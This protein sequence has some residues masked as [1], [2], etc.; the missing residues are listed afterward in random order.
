MQT[1][2]CSNNIISESR[3]LLVD[4][5][6]QDQLQIVSKYFGCDFK[7]HVTQAIKLVLR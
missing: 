6:M 2:I 3:L 4:Y 1:F 5:F 7:D